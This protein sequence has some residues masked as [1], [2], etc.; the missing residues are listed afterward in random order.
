MSI[1]RNR[2]LDLYVLW[3]RWGPFGDEGQHQTTPYLTKEEAVSEFKSIFRSKTGNVWEERSS[4]FIAKPE[5]Y[6]ILNESHHP[7]DTLLKDFDFMVSST[8]S[9][10]PDGVFNV[11]KLIC[12]YQYL[13][14]VYTDTYI[15]MP[16]GQVSQ[17]R[18]DQAYK[19]LLEAR[20]LN[21]KYYTAK[22]KYSDR[23]QAHMAK[24]KYFFKKKETCVIYM[25]V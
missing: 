20:E 22:K 19:T 21:D 24:R 12:N 25:Y 11:M 7:K 5:K 1:I 14:R 4:S 9:N 16:L 8:P 13:S 17:K 23:E 15:D 18:I 3:T 10:L 2:V 6:E